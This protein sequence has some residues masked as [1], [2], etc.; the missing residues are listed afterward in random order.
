[1]SIERLKADIEAAQLKEDLK[2]LRELKTFLS[3]S[4]N[5]KDRT[6]IE[7]IQEQLQRIEKRLQQLDLIA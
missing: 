2:R 5:P 4:N 1:M 3:S 7:D 6:R